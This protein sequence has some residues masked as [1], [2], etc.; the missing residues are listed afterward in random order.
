MSCT[1]HGLKT[2]PHRVVRVQVIARG[3]RAILL[4]ATH[5]SARKVA[6]LVIPYPQQGGITMRS[7]PVILVVL[8]ALFLRCDSTTQS[9]ITPGTG[10]QPC[11]DY[12]C[13]SLAVRAI[14]DANGLDAVPV[15][16][17]VD[18]EGGR[19]HL[20]LLNSMGID[21]LPPEVGCLVT[22]AGIDLDGN[23]L[24]SLPPEIGS[25]S[26]L[27]V[28]EVGDN[29]LTTLPVEIGNLVAM[30]YLDFARNDLASVPAE[31][32]NLTNISWLELQGNNLDSLPHTIIALSHLMV[33]V[34]DNRLLNVT[35]TVAAWLDAN[36]TGGTPWRDCQT[37]VP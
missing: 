24:T 6:W 28:L 8:V 12:T 11:A 20:L 7:A 31:I 21:T 4:F 22:L 35:D 19:V 14:L 26:L 36:A 3:T 32:G 5:A 30:E 9:A 1:Q 37:S 17:V 10:P 13:D 25:L 2:V 16:D 15:G 34:C 29:Y 27:E 33:F 18:L 23:R